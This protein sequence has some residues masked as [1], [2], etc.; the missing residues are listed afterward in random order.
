M[1]QLLGIAAS[2]LRYY[3]QEGLLPFVERSQGGIRMFTEDDLEPLMLIG[4]LKKS[5][6]S[7]KEIRAFIHLVQLGDASLEERLELLR[8][9]REA[10]R[11]QIADLQETLSL[12]EYK[13]WYY[14]TACQAGTEDVV[15]SLLCSEVPPQWRTLLEKLHPDSE[16]GKTY[17]PFHFN[18]R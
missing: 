14:E 2:T 6:L 1:A 12:L 13:C 18:A 9:R 3:D 11:Q 4:C 16:S 8:R 15:R 10:V 7:I 17:S 5:G